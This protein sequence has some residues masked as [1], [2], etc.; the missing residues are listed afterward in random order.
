MERIFIWLTEPSRIATRFEKLNSSSEA[1]ISLACIRI[2]LR[3]SFQTEPSCLVPERKGL[4][5]RP[6]SE[7]D[8]WLKFYTN[9]PRPRTPS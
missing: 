1:V 7:E 4:W 5:Y 8:P 9:A 6:L 3:K 2:C